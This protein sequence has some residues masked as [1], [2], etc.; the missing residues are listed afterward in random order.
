MPYT[1]QSN[2][3]N[4][5]FSQIQAPSYGSFANAFNQ[6]NN[7]LSYDTGINQDIMND[8]GIPAL[9]NPS[10]TGSEGGTFSDFFSNN[11]GG[12]GWGTAAIGAAGGLANAYLGFQGLS[13]ARKQ[14]RMANNQWQAQFDIQKKEYDRQSSERAARVAS[15]QAAINRSATSGGI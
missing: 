8:V 3:L 5:N 14:N 13:E 12:Q 1:N 9:T 15:N 11:K 7:S 10:T 4:L 2:P 6:S